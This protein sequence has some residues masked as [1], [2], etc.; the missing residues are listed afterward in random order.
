MI[1]HIL[2]DLDNTLYSVT[3]GLEGNVVRR[4]KEY[5][6]SWLGLPMEESMRLRDEGMKRYGTTIEWLT[7]EKGFT[8]VDDYNAY[9]HPEDEGDTLAE[10]PQLRSFLES[11]PC[12]CS[13]LTNAPGFHADR[14]IKKLGI[15]G[16][17]KNIFDIESNNL[18]GKPHPSAFNRALEVIAL[19]A[20]EVLFV[21]D[22]PRYVQGYID[23]GGKGIL[24]D[25]LDKHPDF[26]HPR[27]K[28]VYEITR[29]LN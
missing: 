25:E 8:D 14:F 4:M 18:K 10:D 15:E 17:F 12:P 24:V 3:N 5:T 11:L 13:I 23:L 19:K 20:E 6:A 7:A 28:T 16:I 9:A 27:I 26:P 2:F 21:D 29:F 1:R 22:V